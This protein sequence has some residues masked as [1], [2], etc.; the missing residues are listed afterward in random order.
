MITVLHRGGS[1]QMITILHRGGPKMITVL[2][3]GWS[4]K[5]LQYTMN[6]WLLHEEYHFHRLQIFSVG[7][8]HFWRVCQNDYSITLDGYGEMTPKSDYV[9]FARPLIVNLPKFMNS[10]SEYHPTMVTP[11]SPNRSL[12]IVSLQMKW[13]FFIDIVKSGSHLKMF[14]WPLT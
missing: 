11:S 9:I 8:N 7:K 12:F 14:F 6:L 1:S 4:D 5:W 2:H 3:K 13:I 10:I